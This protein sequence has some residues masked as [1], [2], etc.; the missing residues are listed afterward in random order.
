MKTKISLFLCLITHLHSNYT[1]HATNI[2]ELVVTRDQQRPWREVSFFKMGFTNGTSNRQRLAIMQATLLEVDAPIPPLEDRSC[3]F[4]FT[5]FNNPISGNVEGLILDTFLKLPYLTQNNVE[6]LINEHALLLQNLERYLH[7]HGCNTVWIDCAKAE[8][9]GFYQ[10]CG[11]RR[12]G[13]WFKDLTPST[14][15][16]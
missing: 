8:T 13:A 12:D 16:N 1:I 9:E 6:S 2:K 15:R 10:E 4:S 3:H 7:R 14:A 11:Y 5:F